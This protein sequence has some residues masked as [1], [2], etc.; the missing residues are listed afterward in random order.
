MRLGLTSP[1]GH[2]EVWRGA[3]R[4]CRELA[5]WA[6]GQGHDVTWIVTTPE[7]TELTRLEPE[8][9]VVHYQHR[10]VR[11]SGPDPER[12]LLRCIPPIARA[13]R[14]HDLDLVQTHHYVDAAAVR[15][16]SIRHRPYV[17]WI[18]G[19]PRRQSLAGRPAHKVAFRVAVGGAAQLCCLSEFARSR[20]LDDFGLSARVVR[21]GVD[22]ARYA[23]PR[24]D[25]PPTILCAAAPHDPRKR[26]ALLVAAFPEVLAR[27][28]EARLVLAT[29]Q[30]GIATRLLDSLPP[31]ARERAEVTAPSLEGLAEL[32]RRASVS[33]LPSIDEAFGLV[34]VESLAA[35]TPVVASD[36][37]AAREVLSAD[38]V[39]R[40]FA[41]DDRD[42]LVRSIIEAVE[43]SSD[44]GAAAACRAHAEHWDWSKVGPELEELY[45]G[46]I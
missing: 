13:V 32:Y 20:L 24:T 25:G 19:V 18:P 44:P 5:R 37:G 15:L 3:E 17:M 28:P 11:R 10:A 46:V 21:P 42:D 27:V 33:V 2:P 45:A 39:G 26:V 30:E 36:R 35:G 14:R 8:G 38:D 43:L 12:D 16:A 1:Y 6:G 29:Q 23:G 34:M 7:A 22:T 41:H 40:L 31:G 9:I 4:Y